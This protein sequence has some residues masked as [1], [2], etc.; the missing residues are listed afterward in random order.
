MDQIQAEAET[1]GNTLV[2]TQLELAH[3]NDGRTDRSQLKNIKV[4]LIFL[5]H[6]I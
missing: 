2:A 1:V 6:N 4:P 5:Q 3:A